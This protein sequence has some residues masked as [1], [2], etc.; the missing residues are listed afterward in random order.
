MATQREKAMLVGG[1]VAGAAVVGLVAM[2]AFDVGFFGADTESYIILS[3]SESGC[4]AS[5]KQLEVRVGRNKKIDWIV[6]NSCDSPQTVRLVNFR[7]IDNL[8]TSI[9]ENC[10]NPVLEGALPPFQ[11]APPWEVS[12]NGTSDP[13]KPKKTHLKLKTRDTGDDGLPDRVL[14]YQFDICV[15]NRKQ[16]DPRLIVER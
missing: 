1:L 9:P 4:V 6:L 16:V 2:A 7:D 5:G 14:A 10:D 12:A 3:R 13:Y 11:A 8:P 15:E